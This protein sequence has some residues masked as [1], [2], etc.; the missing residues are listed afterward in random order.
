MLK[1]DNVGG[2]VRNGLTFLATF[3]IVALTA[4]TANAIPISIDFGS[5]PINT[6][7]TEFATVSVDA[8]YSIQ[9]A[10]G[11]GINSPFT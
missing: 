6:V 3:S 1:G 11:S 4:A 5:V 2:R 7:A 10:S 8:G 9:L